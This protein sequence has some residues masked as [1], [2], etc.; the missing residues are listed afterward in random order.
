M[1][2]ADMKSMLAMTLFAAVATVS[3]ASAQS[4]TPLAHDPSN[5]VATARCQYTKSDQSCADATIAQLGLRPGPP[6]GPR[7]MPRVHPG[8]SSALPPTVEDRRAAIGALIGLG[9]GVGLACGV[10]S[11]NPNK[12]VV[13]S[14]IFGGFGALIGAMVAHPFP[15]FHTR[16]T[17]SWPG[18]EDPEQEASARSRAHPLRKATQKTTSRGTPSPSAASDNERPFWGSYHW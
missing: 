14:L 7:P 8:Y 17:Y 16:R 4:E 13:G 9:A 12:R 1:Y 5:A 18:N 3:I 15:A 10:Y 2:P 11:D 6:F